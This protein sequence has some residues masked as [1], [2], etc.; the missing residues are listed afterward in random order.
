MSESRKMRILQG[1]PTA[2]GFAVGPV[3]ICHG[4][5]KIPVAEYVIE[6]GRQED[7]VLRYRKALGDAKRDV[8]GIIARSRSVQGAKT[9]WS[10]NAILCFLKILNFP[11]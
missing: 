2:R 3:F 1:L 10:S 8:E 6:S 7:E 9:R 4:D 5:S 11:V